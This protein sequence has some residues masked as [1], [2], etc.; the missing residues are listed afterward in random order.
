MC[1]C[2]ELERKEFFLLICKNRIESD[3]GNNS[4][5]NFH[6]SFLFLRRDSLLYWEKK[7]PNQHTLYTIENMVH[8][9]RN[10]KLINLLQEQKQKVL[11]LYTFWENNSVKFFVPLKSVKRDAKRNEL[12]LHCL[13]NW[14]GIRSF[15]I[16]LFSKVKN[17]LK[18]KW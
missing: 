17:K 4:R 12:F 18:V 14:E 1:S 13:S 6:F 11:F 9:R 5:K 16:V 8:P 7:H 3:K 10:Q 15:K 2:I